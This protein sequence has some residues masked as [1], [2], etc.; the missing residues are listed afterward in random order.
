MLHNDGILLIESIGNLQYLSVNSE[1]DTQAFQLIV[2]L[3]T[4]QYHPKS[5]I[6]K[7][8]LNKNKLTVKTINTIDKWYNFRIFVPTL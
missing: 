5:S 7:V 1:V 2:F 4:L 8:K 3:K 6:K